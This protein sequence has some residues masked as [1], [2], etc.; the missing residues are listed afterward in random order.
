[1]AD[2]KISD[3]TSATAF[4]GSAVMPIVVSGTNQKISATNL[5]GNIQDPVVVNSLS[6]NNDTVIKGQ[7]D[8]TL[9]YVDASTNRVGF[10]TSTPQTLVDV[11]GSLTVAGVIYNNSLNTQAV[12]GSV[13]LTT[14][15]TVVDSA[16]AT[17]LQIA[18][19]T[20]GQIKTIVR[21]GSGSVTMTTTSTIIGGSTITLNAIGSSV[22]VKFI[23][24]AWY[25]V[26]GYNV[27]LS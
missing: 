21:K 25:I 12:S 14:A 6:E 10:S 7:T 20:S 3:M 18:S 2:I 19:G 24:G 27:T 9:F 11:D 23:D 15:T 1:M 4:A 22:V 17:A 8:A 5:F 16:S 13:D 26:G